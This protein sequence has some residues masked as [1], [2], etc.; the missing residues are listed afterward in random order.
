MLLD[1]IVDY[2]PSPLDV[3][4]RPGAH[5]D[6]GDPVTFEASV[7]APLSALAFKIMSDP[8]VGKLAFIRVYSGAMTQG[9]GVYNATGISGN[10]SGA[11]CRCTPTTGRI[12]RRW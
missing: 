3:P 9:M 8:F 10:G 7:D 2:L 5:P 6:T 11:C 1:A 12:C 4:Q